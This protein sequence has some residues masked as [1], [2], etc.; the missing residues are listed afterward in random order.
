MVSHAITPQQATLILATASWKGSHAAKMAMTPSDR[1]RA[2]LRVLR[3]THHELLGVRKRRLCSNRAVLG[4]GAWAH[5]GRRGLTA[6]CDPRGPCFASGRCRCRVGAGACD[7]LVDGLSS[8][9]HI[10]SGREREPE[11][12]DRRSADCQPGGHRGCRPGVGFPLP[13]SATPARRRRTTSSRGERRG[14]LRRAAP[15]LFPQPFEQVTDALLDS[16]NGIRHRCGRSGINSLPLRA[17]G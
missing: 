6:S 12:L 13:L 10:T 17:L 14:T 4:A 3:R 2:M 11:K 1:P 8:W 7:R 16:V 9:H 15:R 5:R